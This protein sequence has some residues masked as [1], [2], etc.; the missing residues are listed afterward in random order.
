[1]FPGWFFYVALIFLGVAEFTVFALTNVSID[2]SAILPMARPLFFYGGFLAIVWCTQRYLYSILPEESRKACEHYF[3]RIFALFAGFAF[4]Y[5]A[6]IAVNLFNYSGM[7]FSGPYQDARL[8]AWDKSLGF[9]WLAYFSFIARHAYLRGLLMTAYR[10]LALV[11]VAVFITLIIVGRIRQAEFYL[12]AFFSGALACMTIGFFMP[13]QGAVA[14]LIHDPGL[15]R[16]FIHTPGVYF[17]QQLTLIKTPGPVALDLTN[18]KG[19]TTFPSFHVA[20]GI[21]M[22]WGCRRTWFFWPVVTYAAIMMFST[23]VFGGHY[24]VD[25]AAGAM[26]GASVCLG[27]GRVKRYR[28]PHLVA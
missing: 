23:P 11:S 12:A 14:F 6:F 15:L 1:M 24:F 21:I 17:V 19:L 22:S 10:L 8:A 18:L 9:N 26:V 27:I 7:R 13:A 3:P 20:A 2:S 25:I 16:Y 5:V 28:V 4:L